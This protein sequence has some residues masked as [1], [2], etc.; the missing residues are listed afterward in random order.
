MQKRGGDIRKVQQLRQIVQNLRVRPSPPGLITHE[1]VRSEG[2]GRAKKQGEDLAGILRTGIDPFALLTEET[3]I[4]SARIARGTTFAAYQTEFF[5]LL[6][7]EY[8]VR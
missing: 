4:E 3:F 6:I 1:I 2:F 5:G 8:T 7:S